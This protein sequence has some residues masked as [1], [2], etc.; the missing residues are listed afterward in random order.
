MGKNHVRSSFSRVRL[1]VLFAALACVQVAHAQALP[2]GQWAITG[3]STETI[4]SGGTLTR[5]G[6]FGSAAN[7]PTYTAPAGGGL[8]QTQAGSPPLANG[9]RPAISFASKIPAAALLAG[10]AAYASTFGTVALLGLTAWQI[11]M[12]NSGVQPNTNPATNAANPFLVQDPTVCTVAPCYG[13]K[14]EFSST[15]VHTS[16]SAACSAVV[17]GWNGYGN[18]YTY[19]LDGMY[20]PPTYGCTVSHRPTAGGTWVAASEALTRVS[21]APQEAVWLPSSMNDI[22]PY[23]TPRSPGLTLADDLLAAG[24]PL[25]SEPMTP[26]GPATSSGQPKTQEEI[27]PAVTTTGTERLSGNPYGIA[28][29]TPTVTSSSSTMV[30]ATSPNGVIYS[31]PKTRTV[32]STYD[33]VSNTTTSTIT[34]TIPKTRV[35]QTTTPT[36]SISYDPGRATATTLKNGTTTVIN[37]DTGE[38]IG[39]STSTDTNPNEDDKETDVCRLHPTSAGCA[40]LGQAPA[41][42]PLKRLPNYAMTV[43]AAAFASGSGCPSPIP[44]TVFGK[45]YSVS[46]S[47]LCAGLAALKNLF[48]AMAAV[49]AAWII[50]DS[51][52]V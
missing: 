47:S 31:A 3:A 52:K 30:Q 49:M 24:I 34:E 38:Q 4:T 40:E 50:A 46:Y 22:A 19:R 20:G 41:G 14:T 6:P 37:D 1:G 2:T 25:A 44:L 5:P 33:P 21:I 23:M 32:T 28:A 8:V 42:E 10:A 35:S 18:G 15:I 43:T 36:T 29:N 12:A 16:Q 26:T 48:L 7:A 45:T 11:W 27:I 17:A 9:T 13:Y 51:F 39:T